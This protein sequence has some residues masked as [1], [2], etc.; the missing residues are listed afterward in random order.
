MKCSYYFVRLL[1]KVR[2]SCRSLPE[3]FPSCFDVLSHSRSS[4]SVCSTIATI[5]YQTPMRL[6]SKFLYLYY[7]ATAFLHLATFFSLIVAKRQLEFFLNFEPC[8]NSC[9]EQISPEKLQASVSMISKMA[10]GDSIWIASMSDNVQEL[11]QDELHL[12]PGCNRIRVM[13]L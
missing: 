3:F 5:V 10:S 8:M 4:I 9:S 12:P 13:T 7:L 2:L 1:L 6:L 11:Q